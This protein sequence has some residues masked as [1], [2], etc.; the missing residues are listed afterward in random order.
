MQA[1]APVLALLAVLWVIGGQAVAASD[2]PDSSPIA[3]RFTSVS[4]PGAPVSRT[5]EHFKQRIESGSNGAIQ[6]QIFFSSK[7]YSDV[8]TLPAVS[9]G[10][11]EMGFV[12]LARYTDKVPI[13]DAF[14]LPFVFNTET[15]EMA[16]IAPDSEIRHMID[17]AILAQTGTRPLWWI[18]LGRTVLLTKG[19]P[20][21]NPQAIEN[22]AVRTFGHTIESVVK[23]CGGRPVDI[24]SSDQ[25]NAYGSGKVDVG[26][27]GIVTV[28]GRKLW[29]F[30][31][32]LTITNQ[33]SMQSLIV[34]NE[35]F[36]QKLPASHRALIEA[37]GRD[38]DAE[39]RSIVTQIERDA[40]KKL[41]DGNGVKIVA[42]SDDDLVLW[43]ICSSDVL[44]EFMDRSGESGQALM[45]AYGRMKLRLENA[46]TGTSR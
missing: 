46:G 32:T 16:A 12:N 26:M 41:A 3:I 17:I 8:Q 4:D 25:E 5:I 13:A 38:L 14:Q 11:A 21:A 19:A 34:M 23:Y 24:E 30:M 2:T 6:V 10:G 45:T 28:V 20:A 22:K 42:L 29:R 7:L 18:P 35:A 15:L 44:Q 39:A 37:A 40:Y 9:S 27:T 31:D 36:W 1:S 33:A 43:R